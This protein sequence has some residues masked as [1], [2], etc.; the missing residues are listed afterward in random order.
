MDHAVYDQEQ[1]ATGNR[2]QLPRL[3]EHQRLVD[4]RA[5]L[6]GRSQNLLQAI[7][8]L[9]A[10]QGRLL[11]PAHRGL[12]QRSRTGRGARIGQTSGGYD[13]PWDRC[14]RGC[15]AARAGAASDGYPECGAQPGFRLQIGQGGTG[16]G[17][18]F[19]QAV[20]ECQLLQPASQSLPV[21]FRVHWP[22]VFQ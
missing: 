19:R 9:D 3:T 8:V 7:E 5:L 1:V 2:Y 21:Q 13:D 10:R 16:L 11:A 20:R 14:W 18:H 12:H 15:I 4:A 6:L 17:N 22:V